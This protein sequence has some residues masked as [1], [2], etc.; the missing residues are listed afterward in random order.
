MVVFVEA[1]SVLVMTAF[2]VAVRIV[3]VA[4]RPF[5]VRSLLM[6]AGALRTLPGDRGA[7][8]GFDEGQIDLHGATERV[9]ARAQARSQQGHAALI[10]QA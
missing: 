6:R 4:T 1:S 9:I 2:H 7:H 5:R 10:A 8:S 3:R